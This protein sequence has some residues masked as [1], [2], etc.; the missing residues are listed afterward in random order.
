MPRN[1]SGCHVE[2]PRQT[3]NNA[4][5]SGDGQRT[6]LPSSQLLLRKFNVGAEGAVSA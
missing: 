4:T 2:I 6:G 3:R 1:A 5:E